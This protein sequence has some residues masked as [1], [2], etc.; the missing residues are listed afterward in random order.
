M[1]HQGEILSW[2]HK[3]GSKHD[4][5]SEYNLTLEAQLTSN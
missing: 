1:Q 3:D 4:P 2:Y 5:E